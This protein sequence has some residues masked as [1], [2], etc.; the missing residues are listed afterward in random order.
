MTD[1]EQF[2]DAMKTA[3]D[4]ARPVTEDNPIPGLP[5]DPIE[6]YLAVKAAERALTGGSNSKVMEQVRQ[7]TLDFLRGGDGMSV[8]GPY[9]D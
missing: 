1:R 8:F 3:I 7:S 2:H 5:T 4:Q 9:D 6:M